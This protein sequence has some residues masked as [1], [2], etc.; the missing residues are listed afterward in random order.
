[1]EGFPVLGMEAVSM[2]D[3]R[4][5]PSLRELGEWSGVRSGML[6]IWTVEI[7]Q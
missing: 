3:G 2:A 1:V 5:R 4:V 7:S 6:P